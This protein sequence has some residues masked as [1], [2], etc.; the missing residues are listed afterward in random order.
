MA[1]LND[2]HHVSNALDTYLKVCLAT[3]SLTMP[4]G[5]ELQ[6]A[7]TPDAIV[8]LTAHKLTKAVPNEYFPVMQNLKETLCGFGFKA[9]YEIT[10]Q[11]PGHLELVCDLKDP[12]L[13]IALA[14]LEQAT[15]EKMAYQSRLNEIPRLVVLG[16]I[17]NIT[18][19]K[20]N[21][22]PSAHNQI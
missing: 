10:K 22:P 17:N 1:H 4:E 2:Q 9:T 11:K 12:N 7:S 5:F 14:K 13:P 19:G 15:V 18:M 8:L 21:L 6:M 3:H 20:T 16:S